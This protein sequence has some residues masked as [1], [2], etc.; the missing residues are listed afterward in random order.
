M[1]T[2]TKF[3]VVPA[4]GHFSGAT[5]VLSSHR[6]LAAARKAAKAGES[7]RCEVRIGGKKKGD[8]WY[9]DSARYYGTPGN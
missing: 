7:F 1:A 9:A 4:P 3:F 2:E 5:T 6:T 8:K